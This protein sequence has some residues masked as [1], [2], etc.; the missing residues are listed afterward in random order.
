MCLDYSQF[1]VVLRRKGPLYSDDSS[2]NSHVT[3]VEYALSFTQCIRVHN[4]DK[5]GSELTKGQDTQ[6][7]ISGGEETPDHVLVGE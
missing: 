7:K 3:R 5:T 1:S 4:Q 6:D 2:Q